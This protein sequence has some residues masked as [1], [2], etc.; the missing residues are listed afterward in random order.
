MHSPFGVQMS[1]VQRFPSSHLNAS[2]HSPV[3]WLHVYS[4]HGS[5]PRGFSFG[6]NSHSPFSLL[7]TS[8]V[9]SLPSLQPWCTF[10]TATHASASTSHIVVRHLFVLGSHTTSSYVH[11]PVSLLHVS[12]W[13]A[14]WG[15]V[16]SRVHAPVLLSQVAF[17]HRS[18]LTQLLVNSSA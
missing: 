16:G 7:H 12:V 6:M 1:C 18:S 8:F 10:S 3:D 11:A 17:T 5:L 13:H 9:H 4:M 15:H 14:R 2:V